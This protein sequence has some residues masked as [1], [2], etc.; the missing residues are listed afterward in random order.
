MVIYRF[1]LFTRDSSSNSKISVY[2]NS[3][4]RKVGLRVLGEAQIIIRGDAAL[5][6]GA[7]QCTPYIIQSSKSS[8]ESW[9]VVETM[10]RNP[11]LFW[12]LPGPGHI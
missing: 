11:I 5:T 9:R 7:V 3:S 6:A 2:D 1:A 10:P 4:V 8:L 12:I